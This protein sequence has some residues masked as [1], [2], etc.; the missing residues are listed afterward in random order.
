[1]PDQIIVISSMETLNNISIYLQSSNNAMFSFFTVFDELIWNYVGLT[2]I[3]S[4]G[5]YFS[6]K[7]KLFH[8]IL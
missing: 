2:L 1:M 7:S 5:L 8:Y 4:V 3:L 6:Y